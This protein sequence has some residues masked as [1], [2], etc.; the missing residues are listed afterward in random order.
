[1]GIMFLSS[2]SITEHVEYE[3]V[4]EKYIAIGK[5]IDSW[6]LFCSPRAVWLLGGVRGSPPHWPG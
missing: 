1:M 4:N 6:S 3:S 2:I 5:R